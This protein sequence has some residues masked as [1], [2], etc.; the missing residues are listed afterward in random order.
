MAV[1]SRA[2]P[3]QNR[4]PKRLQEG[5]RRTAYPHQ[6]PQGTSTWQTAPT[7]HPFA[8]DRKG[9]VLWLRANVSLADG[10]MCDNGSKTIKDETQT[11]PFWIMDQLGCDSGGGIR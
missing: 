11:R 10:A 1:G 6:K 2:N 7:C 4:C 8:V 9:H 3:G 5:V